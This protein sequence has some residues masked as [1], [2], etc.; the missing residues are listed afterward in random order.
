MTEC[1]FTPKKDTSSATI[2]A[3]CGLEKMLHTIGEGVKVSKVEI[4]T[5]SI[6]TDSPILLAKKL[7][8]SI[9]A[10]DPN[11]IRNYNSS[12]MVIRDLYQQC[13]ILVSSLELL[14]FNQL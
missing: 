11:V 8:R 12:D 1:Y 3:N 14:T 2:C 13:K 6:V 4:I 5:N 7:L 9:V 10:A